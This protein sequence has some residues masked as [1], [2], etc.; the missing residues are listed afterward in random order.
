MERESM[1]GMKKRSLL[2]LRLAAELALLAYFS[3]LSI[4]MFRAPQF[5]LPNYIYFGGPVLSL[6][7]ALCLAFDAARVTRRLHAMFR[8]NSN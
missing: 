3:Y 8:Q 2:T 6:L 5:A 7:I 1:D 4:G